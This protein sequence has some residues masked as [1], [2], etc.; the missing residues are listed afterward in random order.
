MGVTDLVFELEALKA[1]IKGVFSRS[2]C[3]YGNLLC[4][5]IDSNLLTN[6]WT[7]FRYHDFGINLYRVVIMT[8]QTLSIGKHWKLFRATLI[9]FIH[10]FILIHKS[11]TNFV[12]QLQNWKLS[13]QR[14]STFSL[15]LY[16]HFNTG[17]IYLHCVFPSFRQ[18]G[19]DTSME[20]L[21]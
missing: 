3:C 5:K 2:Y 9:K 15:Q 17:H 4:H 18:K 19:N 8:H 16:Q 13:C 20:T 12:I 14:L 10:S 1:K 6:D 7:V 21:F 11:L